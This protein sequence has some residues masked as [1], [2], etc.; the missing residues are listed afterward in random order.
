VGSCAT[1]SSLHADVKVR[2]TW[3]IT[4]SSA[5]SPIRITPVSPLTLTS[6][7][8]TVSLRQ[9]C[10]QSAL[11][12]SHHSLSLPSSTLFCVRPL[13]CPLHSVLLSHHSLSHLPPPHCL[14]PPGLCTVCT[15]VRLTTHS[16]FPPPPHCLPPPGLCHVR[17]A[18]ALRADSLL[19]HPLPLRQAYVFS[20][21][22]LKDLFQVHLV[23]KDWHAI[24]NRYQGMLLTGGDAFTRKVLG[25][26]SQ[27]VTSKSF[28]GILM[29][30]TR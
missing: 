22:E 5:Y 17:P 28:A 23:C 6:L 13:C 11:Q 29:D 7:L 8:H 15:P 20:L 30:G 19:S 24:C 10:T 25:H 26:L 4:P 12:S 2:T 1:F 27:V 14:P 21:L 16:H 18:I 9:D 3:A